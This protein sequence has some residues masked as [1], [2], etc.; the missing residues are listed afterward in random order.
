M[1]ASRTLA[2]LAPL[3]AAAIALSPA[4]ALAQTSIDG[5]YRD[6]DGY[7][8]ITVAPCG[9]ARCGTIARI[10]RM[11]EGETN[12]DR[13]ND[14]PALRDRPI[15]G[16]KVLKNLRWDDGA[17]RGQVYNPE[18]GGTYRAVVNPG[19]DGGLEV[20]GCVTLFCRTVDWP[21]AR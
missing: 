6:Q 13:H 12:R 8:E 1:T 9:N 21:R 7:T 14:D 11:K 10:I 5:V 19:D 2:P 20:K 4:A 17:W 18:D 15:T 3:A 16:I